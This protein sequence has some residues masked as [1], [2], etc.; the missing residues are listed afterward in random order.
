MKRFLPLHTKMI[1]YL[2]EPPNDRLCAK[3]IPHPTY[4]C[5]S[6]CRCLP[7]VVNINIRKLQNREYLMKPR[8]NSL[9]ERVGINWL[10]LPSLS[11]FDVS[12]RPSFGLFLW[13]P[14][15]PKNRKGK[16]PRKVK[17]ELN[18]NFHCVIFLFQYY[19]GL[20]NGKIYRVRIIPNLI[21][22]WRGV[23]LRQSTCHFTSHWR[24]IN[25]FLDKNQFEYPPHLFRNLFNRVLFPLF[26]GSPQ[27]F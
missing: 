11:L 19:R 26:F 13:L 1:E 15:S 27:R 17:R 21:V 20:A 12:S 5:T 3:N 23:N 16:S 10:I 4:L 6:I 2:N 14:R 24:N 18:W 9:G 7:I 22:K 8:I 25:G